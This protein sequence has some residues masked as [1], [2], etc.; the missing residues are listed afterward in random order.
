MKDSACGRARASTG[1][2]ARAGAKALVTT[3][4]GNLCAQE[5]PPHETL[6]KDTYD[7]FGVFETALQENVGVFHTSSLEWYRNSKRIVTCATSGAPGSAW[8]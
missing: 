6:H 8:P 4:G 3:Q 2:Q 5:Q 1:G 7:A